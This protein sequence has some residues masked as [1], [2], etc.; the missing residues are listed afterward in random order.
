MIDEVFEAHVKHTISKIQNHHAFGI[1]GTYPGGQKKS[2]P[3]RAESLALAIDLAEEFE[4]WMHDHIKLSYAKWLS[5]NQVPL[6]IKWASMAKKPD[7]YDI[8][9]FL[10][11]EYSI[12]LDNI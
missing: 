2:I 12:Y 1:G 9:Q 6:S 3:F 10:A 4:Q 11:D 7:Y 5:V 8:K